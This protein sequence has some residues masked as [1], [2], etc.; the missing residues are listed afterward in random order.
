MLSKNTSA[1]DFDIS[2]FGLEENF[3][4]KQTEP[5]PKKEMVSQKMQEI[6]IKMSKGQVPQ[7]TDSKQIYYGECVTYFSAAADPQIYTAT[8]AIQEDIP[9]RMKIGYSL[10]QG[11][12]NEYTTS[13][14]EKLKLLYSAKSR[15]VTPVKSEEYDGT[16]LDVLIAEETPGFPK[17]VA[18]LSSDKEDSSLMYLIAPVM[19]YYCELKEVK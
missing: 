11:S 8:L 1:I 9:G 17:I 16:Y 10:S 18:T 6:F 4:K 15:K 19:G 14:L 3:K 5:F 2:V 13:D 12:L 7:P